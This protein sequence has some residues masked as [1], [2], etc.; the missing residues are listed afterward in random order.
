MA[1]IGLRLSE[2]IQDLK[3]DQ[4]L[5]PTREAIS[6][7]LTVGSTNFFKAVE[8]VRGRLQQRI[9]S[10]TSIASDISQSTTVDVSKSETDLTQSPELSK[11]EIEV[12]RQVPPDSR[13][14]P[15]SSRPASVA[16]AAADTKAV[17]SSWGVGIQ[18]LWTSRSARF[19]G[20]RSSIASV[21]SRE[22][23]AGP[24]PPLSAASTAAASGVASPT[25][26]RTM[27]E[28]VPEVSEPFV[29]EDHLDHT[30]QEEIQHGEPTGMAL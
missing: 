23:S 18:S 27:V 14:S 1:D 22:S 19:S 16:Q 7:T 26:Q 21:A 10:S 6:R 11:Q 25:Q 5:T 20:A 30:E 12:A 28:P 17:L 13:T 4:Q 24:T 9:A 2:G 15:V 29:V 8:G 3:L